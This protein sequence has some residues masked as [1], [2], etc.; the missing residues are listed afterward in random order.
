[1]FCNFQVNGSIWETN[2]V[3]WPI[4]SY[5][6]FKEETYERP[7]SHQD[8][9]SFELNNVG[10]TTKDTIHEVN[11]NAHDMFIGVG[12]NKAVFPTDATKN[13]SEIYQRNSDELTFNSVVDFYCR[14]KDESIS[15]LNCHLDDM[16]VNIYLLLFYFSM[17][18]NCNANHFRKLMMLLLFLVI[19]L[20][21]QK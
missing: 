5:N 11:R 4:H 9:F 14:L 18:I 10:S 15:L 16:K 19:E 1:M 12:N 2:L 20:K 7:L 6:N 3:D 21:Q 17:F 8:E 13:E